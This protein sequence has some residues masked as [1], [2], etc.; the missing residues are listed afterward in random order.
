[1]QSGNHRITKSFQ[2]HRTRHTDKLRDLLQL[3]PSDSLLL[4]ACAR[5]T[6]EEVSRLLTALPELNPDT[7]RDKYL[8]TPLH[9]A[10]GRQDD[11]GEATELAKVLILAGSDVNN[12]VGDID[13]LQPMHMAVLANNV[14]CV[15][16]LLEHGASVPASDPFR[17][18]PLLLAKLKLDNLRLTQQLIQRASNGRFEERRM[19][20]SAQSEY[21]DLESITE[22]LVT[23]L[24]NKHITTFGSPRHLS[25]TH[26]LS[27]F[28]FANAD[29]D[30]LS[31]VISGIAAQF[32][33]LHMN[34]RPTTPEEAEIKVQKLHDSMNG[35]IE[36]VRQLGINDKAKVKGP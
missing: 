16:L 10:C 30:G 9:I 3:S 22:V 13:G 36:K 24:S 18:T 32:S 26:G 25:S 17:L 19:S 31:E 5:K 29:D 27:D 2:S 15:L 21:G 35:L 7:I 4:D 11:L 20:S 34:D 12:G 14:Q 33:N 28:L 6:A 1:M 8:R 23:H